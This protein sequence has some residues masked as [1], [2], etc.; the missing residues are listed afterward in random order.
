MDVPRSF[1]PGTDWLF[2]KLYT[3]PAM[4]DQV[5]QDVVR[6]AVQQG[7][8]AGVVDRWF[9]IRHG[10]PDWHLRLRFHCDPSRLG[11][12]VLPVLQA[13]LDPWLG[14]GRIWRIQL[15]TYEREVERYGGAAGI[16]LAER[17][18]QADSEAVLALTELFAEDAR[19]KLRWRL[20]LAGMHLLLG[21]LGLDLEARLVVVRQ[22]RDAFIAEFL[23]DAEFEHQLAARF[24]K[25]R[26][27]LEALLEPAVVVDKGLAAGMEVLRRRSLKLTPVVAE[28]RACAQS[29]RLSVPLTELAVSYMHMHANRMLRSAQRA[30]ELV[31]YDFLRVSINRKRRASLAPIF[32]GGGP[33]GRL[34]KSARIR[35]WQHSK[36]VRYTKHR[37]TVRAA[38]APGIGIRGRRGR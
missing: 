35:R 20:A 26:K 15:D 24:R 13:A 19:G 14:D 4:A 23:A 6:P 3:S 38:E 2:V 30:Q 1:V 11:G 16:E 29:G 27:D 32:R 7:V 10:D 21:N 37:R 18:F 31:L 5:L 25:E 8:P 22:A 33:G 17:V 28:L 9:F 12:E 36:S 34:A